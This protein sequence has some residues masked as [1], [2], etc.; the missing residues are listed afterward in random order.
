MFF[1]AGSS[2]T[3]I[4]LVANGESLGTLDACD[5]I[6]TIFGLL[7]K[8][9]ESTPAVIWTSD[10]V[11]RKARLLDRSNHWAMAPV[12][13]DYMGGIECHRQSLKLFTGDSP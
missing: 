12:T 10:L 2:V 9:S 13:D 6:V 11:I 3:K 7:Q 1:R 8:K 4:R 5:M